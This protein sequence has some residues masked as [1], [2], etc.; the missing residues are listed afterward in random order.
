M[1]TVITG[2]AVALDLPAASL[3]TRGASLLI[4][5]LIYW[6]GLVLTFALLG[7]L[8]VGFDGVS[9]DEAAFMA[10]QLSLLVLFT[11][12]VPMTVETLSRGRSVGKLIFGLR[13][14][15]DDGGAIRLRHSLIR[16]LTGF[17]EIYLTLGLL[18]LITA[19]FTQRGKRLGDVLAGTY[20]IRTRHP[21]VA[22]MMLPVPQHMAS[23]TQIAD[24]GRIPDELAAQAARLL[25]TVERATAR[26]GKGANMPALTATAGRLAD[27][28]L[29]YVSPLPPTSSALEFLAAVMAERRNREYQK[30]MRELQRQA[31]LQQR[32]HALPYS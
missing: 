32:I 20:A 24:I 19:M 23:W 12:V 16:W 3:I 2:E 28:M 7:I 29:P 5:L 4:D 26:G 8:G 15:R 11:V 25:R 22:P 9:F 30:L 10:L 6:L 21:N 17:G 31:P 18:P 14:V 13:V 1:R 27:E